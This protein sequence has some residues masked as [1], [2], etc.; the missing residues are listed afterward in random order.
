MKN[1]L[2]TL[3]AGLFLGSVLLSACGVSVGSPS[4]NDGSKIAQFSYVDM[5][6]GN[7]VKVYEVKD[8]KG[9]TYILAVSEDGVAICP[10]KE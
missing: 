1:L 2:L 8:S 7:T 3:A 4:E 6:L 5:A 10:A 9:A